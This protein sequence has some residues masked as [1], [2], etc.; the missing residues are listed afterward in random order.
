MV[1]EKS[2]ALLEYSKKYIN[3]V[4]CKFIDE[5]VAECEMSEVARKAAASKSKINNVLT[6][7]IIINN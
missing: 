1:L 2:I 7:I 4:F 6:I 5:V 3:C